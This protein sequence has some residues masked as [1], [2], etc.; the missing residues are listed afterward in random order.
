MQHI[1]KIRNA[2]TIN[3]IFIFIH[4]VFDIGHRKHHINAKLIETVAR[5]SFFVCL[6]LFMDVGKL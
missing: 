5:T 2:L 4:H 3:L 1:C 6:L